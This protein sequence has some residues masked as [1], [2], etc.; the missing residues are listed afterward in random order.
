MVHVLEPLGL[1]EE[2]EA[3]Y[4]ELVRVGAST[5][6][7]AGKSLKLTAAV[8]RR[9]AADLEQLGLVNSGPEGTVT[10][11]PPR[12]ALEPLINERMRSL[13]QT[14]R[15][16]WEL[17]ELHAEHQ[18]TDALSAH[19]VDAIPSHEAVV[20]RDAQLTRA[21]TTQIRAFDTP[22]YINVPG[23]VSD[24][25]LDALNR[26]VVHRVIYASSALEEPNALESVEIYTRSGEDARV[27]NDLPLKMTIFDDEV[28]MVGYRF[29]AAEGYAAL[30][31][32][33]SPLLTAL[34][35]LFELNWR[36]ATPIHLGSDDPA[37]RW[38]ISD[39]DLR[40]V[41]LMAA[42][43]KEEAI[44]RQLGVSERTISRRTRALLE[45]FHVR[46]R[47]QLLLTFAQRGLLPREEPDPAV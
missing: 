18:L 19:L 47:Q 15:S 12:L 1:T 45:L 26:G 22:P 27:T 41:T 7:R 5:P 6:A 32:H 20:L 39:D 34:S 4:R 30:L 28:A 46:S 3:F 42:G 31:V 11:V 16:V 29:P 13:E 2:Q 10:A 23:D 17:V 33:P 8:S 25:E 9:T 37:A 43:L 14:R 44:G 38:G 24:D 21:A 36:L 35:E 40:L